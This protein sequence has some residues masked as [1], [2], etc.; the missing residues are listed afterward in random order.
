MELTKTIAENLHCLLPYRVPSVR[1]PAWQ[2][3][4]PSQSPS[5]HMLVQQLVDEG[6]THFGE[7]LQWME[8]GTPLPTHPQRERL[9]PN[10]PAL[11]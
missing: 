5:W 3:V 7:C 11:T 8:L 1:V 2:F 6:T 9:A 10:Q 4:G